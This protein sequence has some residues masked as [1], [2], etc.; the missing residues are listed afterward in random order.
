MGEPAF[1]KLRPAL[2]RFNVVFNMLFQC[3]QHKKRRFRRDDSIAAAH[4]QEAVA[5]EFRFHHHLLDFPLRPEARY[6]ARVGDR[7]SLQCHFPPRDFRFAVA[8]AKHHARL[9]RDQLAGHMHTA[10]YRLPCRRIK[11]SD[12]ARVIVDTEQ[13]EGFEIDLR[14]RRVVRHDAEVEMCAATR[15]R[16]VP[17]EQMVGRGRRRYREYG[18]LWCVGCFP[19]GADA[20]TDKKIEIVRLAIE[21]L[22]ELHIG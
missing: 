15:G 11:V 3:L 18:D 19:N 10:R 12:L 14:E 6:Q 4:S 5:V 13:R 22:V 2:G 7:G 21:A 8:I 9:I 17:K 1:S 20:V 16:Q